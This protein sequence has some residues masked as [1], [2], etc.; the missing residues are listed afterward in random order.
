M[1]AKRHDIVVN[2][3]QCG[4]T[5][6]DAGGRVYGA[7]VLPLSDAGRVSAGEL[8]RQL[9]PK[10]R[11]TVYHPDDD[12]AEETARIVARRI[13][14]KTRAVVDLA[15]PNL[16]LLDGLTEQEFAERFSKRFKQWEEDPLSLNP[17]EGEDLWEAR[18]RILKALARVMRRS[19]ASEIVIVLHTL[20][21]G[22][23][24]AH[25]ADRQPGYLWEAVRDRPPVE[26]YAFNGDLIANLEQTAEAIPAHGSA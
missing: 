16:G 2:L 18:S 6:W 12:A 19:R 3:C 1:A 20:A 11:G 14:A 8:A 15:D 17:P 9:R 23:L 5:S 22:F 10:M 13:G 4:Q 21:Y 26:R 25:C 24:R 7:T